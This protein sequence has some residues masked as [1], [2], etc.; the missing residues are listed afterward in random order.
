MATPNSSGGLQSY[1]IGSDRVRKILSSSSDER[2]KLISGAK[3]R[4]KKSPTNRGDRALL[5]SSAAPLLQLSRVLTIG[6]SRPKVVC[7]GIRIF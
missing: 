7:V 1:R 6:K 4:R 2:R 3:S 5:L